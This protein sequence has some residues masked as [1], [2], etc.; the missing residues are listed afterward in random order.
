MRVLKRFEAKDIN[1][2]RLVGKGLNDI[3]SKDEAFAK[4]E[5]GGLDVVCVNEDSNP[6]VVRIEDFNKLEYDRKKKTKQKTRSSTLKEVQFKMRIAEHDLGIKIN[7]VK[8]FL[9]RGDK[10]KASVRLRGR[11]RANP[12][13]AR[14]LI[15]QVAERVGA[16]IT[17]G[18]NPAVAILEPSTKAASGGSGS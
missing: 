15:K 17:S 14:D 8:E 11:E 3:V 12:E 7:R 5:E 13:M 9:D 6:M 4:A 18:G 10:V 1:Q 2:V 16:K